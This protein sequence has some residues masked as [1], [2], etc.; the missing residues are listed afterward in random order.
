MTRHELHVKF[1]LQ[2]T[3]DVQPLIRYNTT[4]STLLLHISV[5]EQQIQTQ[6]HTYTHKMELMHS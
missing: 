3:D 4:A 2:I 5:T 1:H 6:G